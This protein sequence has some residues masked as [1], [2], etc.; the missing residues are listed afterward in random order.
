V[1]KKKPHKVKPIVSDIVPTE[2]RLNSHIHS[3]ERYAQ[4]GIQP[5][6]Y[7]FENNLDFFQGSVVK[8]ITRH[9]D[10]DGL[11]DVKKAMHF[12]ILLAEREYGVKLVV[13]ERTGHVEDITIGDHVGSDD[14]I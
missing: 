14:I 8:Y 5:I 11:E 13:D 9:K 1:K 7:I 12:C 2:D 4:Y 10:K 3:R 6:D